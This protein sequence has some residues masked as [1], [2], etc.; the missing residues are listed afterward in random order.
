[1]IYFNDKIEP[2]F[3]PINYHPWAQLQSK[4]KLTGAEVKEKQALEMRKM[5]VTERVYQRLSKDKEVQGRIQQIKAHPWV[6]VVEGNT[7]A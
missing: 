4:S 7:D 5:A 3:E 2:H 1:M 6:L